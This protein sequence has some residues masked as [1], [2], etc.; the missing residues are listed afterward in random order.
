MRSGGARTRA[1]AGRRRAVLGTS[2]YA[3]PVLEVARN[4]IGCV[5][6]HGEPRRA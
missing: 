5:V 4:L 1:V 6:S 2:F 3:R